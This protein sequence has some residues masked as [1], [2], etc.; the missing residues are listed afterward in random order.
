[1]ARTLRILLDKLV[2]PECP[3]W[4]DGELYFSNVYVGEV[5]AMRPDGAHRVVLKHEGSVS[6]L[7]WLPDG[8]LLFVSGN[9]RKL[10]RQER[11]GQVVVHADLSHI[12][13]SNTNDM[14]V[15]REGRAYVGN[16]GPSLGPQGGRGP[17]K[18]ALVQPDGGV[19]V[20]AEG[21]TF[22]NGSVITPDAKTLIVA[23]SFG[24]AL[25]AF[26]IG[27]N[28]A[29]SNKRRWAN[30]DLPAIPDGICI[31]AEGA[32]WVASPM[33]NEVMRI[34]EGGEIVERIPTGRMAVACML[35]GADRKTLFVLTSEAL[36]HVV[37]MEKVSARVEAVEVEAPGAGWP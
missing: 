9:D 25:T 19:S 15:D 1:M 8:R 35:G 34:K 10:M 23:E 27:A 29:L 36:D 33:S 22:P 11:D 14:V 26:D 5:L 20:A 24:R 3:R 17:T 16:L 31:D 21:V 30:I 12:A 4:R 13:E 37:T 28:G 7:G 18:L 6:G 2:F 32:V